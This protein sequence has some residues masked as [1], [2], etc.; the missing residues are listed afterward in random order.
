MEDDRWVY[1]AKVELTRDVDLSHSLLPVQFREK[2]ITR[3][4]Q[5]K[6]RLTPHGEF[7]VSDLRLT[8][9]EVSTLKRGE[10]LTITV[11]AKGAY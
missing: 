1:N 9:G 10:A 11:V 3:P 4:I 5:A 2:Q 8:P 7:S 6:L